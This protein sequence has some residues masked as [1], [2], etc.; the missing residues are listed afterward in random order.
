MIENARVHL[1]VAIEHLEARN[2]DRADEDIRIAQ[3]YALIALA[4]A[5]N[6]LAQ[7]E[8]HAHE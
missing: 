3:V 7:R 2:F 8:A 4:E 1:E 6:R 5:L